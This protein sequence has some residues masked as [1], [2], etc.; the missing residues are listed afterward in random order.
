MARLTSRVLQYAKP[1]LGDGGTHCLE[2]MGTY[3]GCVM[4]MVA[5]VMTALGAFM[6]LICVVLELLRIRE[7]KKTSWGG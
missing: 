3:Q 1:N 5:V 7:W 4:L 6:A 2:N